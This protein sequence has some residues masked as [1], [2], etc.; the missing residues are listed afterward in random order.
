MSILLLTSLVGCAAPLAPV[1]QLPITTTP[2]FDSSQIRNSIEFTKVVIALE[3]GEV[4]G[5]LG[6][7]ILCI[8]GPPLKWDGGTP[9]LS[10]GPLVGT[11]RD[12]FAK[13]GIKLAGDPK[14]LFNVGPDSQ[15]ELV[16]AAK[17]EKVDLRICGVGTYAGQKGSAYVKVEWQVF[18]RTAG[19][20][21]LTTTSE[22]SFETTEFK[23]QAT[24]WIAGAVEESTRR[25]LSNPDARKLFGTPVSRPGTGEPIRS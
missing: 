21:V 12:T 10:E 18:S 3:R 22:G 11:I 16:V 2:T 13:A 20:V 8:P 9:T 7:G 25:F 19:T 15:G 17:I 23:P 24:G 6:N 4:F 5:Q 14:Q 1:K